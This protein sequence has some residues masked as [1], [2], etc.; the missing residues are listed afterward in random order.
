MIFFGRIEDEV[1]NLSLLIDGYKRSDL[2]DN[3][4]NLV[5]LGDGAD[6]LKL[7]QKVQ[8]MS[9]TRCDLCEFP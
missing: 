6:K 7:E 9:L 8:A 2:I 1:K 4:I 5:I 3:N